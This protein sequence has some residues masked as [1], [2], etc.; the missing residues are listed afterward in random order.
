VVNTPPFSGLVKDDQAG[1]VENDDI[2]LTDNV[3]MEE[4]KSVSLE[5]QDLQNNDDI[6]LTDNVKKGQGKQQIA[7]CEYEPCGKEFIQTVS[8]KRFCCDDCR[9]LNWELIHGKKLNLKTA[10]AG[11]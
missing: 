5:K 7:V 10:A 2:R 3:R 11:G 9:K 4:K 8:W 1:S 6:R